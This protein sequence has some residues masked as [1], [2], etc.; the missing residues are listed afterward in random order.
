MHI[1]QRHSLRTFFA[2]AFVLAL[3]FGGVR[4][5]GQ[6]GRRLWRQHGYLPNGAMVL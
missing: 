1:W 5:S 4:A 6:R 3:V 2:M